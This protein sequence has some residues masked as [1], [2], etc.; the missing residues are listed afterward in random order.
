MDNARHCPQNLP[1]YPRKACRNRTSKGSR[2]KKHQPSDIWIEGHE[3]VL[4]NFQDCE[5]GEFS[6]SV[7]K[8][9]DHV[10]GDMEV[11]QVDQAGD[12]LG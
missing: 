5:L 7:G 11:G 8:L 2:T 9:F 12:F 4:I 6:D 1:T 10:D 3:P